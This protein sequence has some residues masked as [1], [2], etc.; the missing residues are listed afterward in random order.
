[1]QTPRDNNRV[2]ALMGVLYSD[3]VTLVPIA[4]N[5][6]GEIETEEVLTLSAPLP[7]VAGR[8][9]NRETVLMGVSSVDGTTLVPVFVTVS[10][11]VLIET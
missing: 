10:G 11:K 7:T 9:E 5:A 6:S 4:I 1:M 2:P 3:G 8:D